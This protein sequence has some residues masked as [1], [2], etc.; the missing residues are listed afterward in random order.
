[1]ELDTTLI[2]QVVFMLFCLIC[3]GIAGLKIADVFYLKLIDWLIPDNELFKKGKVR[4][5]ASQGRSP[6]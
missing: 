5:S 2:T 3:V 6:G 4:I 1:M